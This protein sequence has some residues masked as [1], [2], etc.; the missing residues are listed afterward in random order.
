MID[1]LLAY[2]GVPVEIPVVLVVAVMVLGATGFADP[3]RY[4]RRR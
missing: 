1:W 3:P 2:L 4:Q